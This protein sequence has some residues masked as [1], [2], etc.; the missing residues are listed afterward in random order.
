MS[1]HDIGGAIR[2]GNVTGTLRVLAQLGSLGIVYALVVRSYGSGVLGTWVLLQTLSTYGGL[3]HLGMGTLLSRRIAEK[4]EVRPSALCQVVGLGESLTLG[5]LFSLCLSVALLIVPWRLVGV[6]ASPILLLGLSAAASLRLFAGIYGG[7]L[8]GIHRNSSVNVSQMV[9]SIA[10]LLGYMLSPLSWT[11]LSRLAFGSLLSSTA[12]G[13]VILGSLHRRLPEALMVRPILNPTRLAELSRRAF[14]FLAVDG[15]LLGREPL[16]KLAAFASGG[17]LATASVEIASRVPSA[18]RQG[19]VFGFA[20]LLP[21][22]SSLAA[23]NRSSEIVDVGRRALRFVVLGAGLALFAYALLANELLRLWL[24]PSIPQDAVRLTRLFA[25]WWAV[26]AL[27]VPAWW[28]GM[29]VGHPG[30]NLK[31]AAYHTGSAAVIAVFAGVFK[32]SLL[33]IVLLWIGSGLVMQ[34]PLYSLT[35]RRTR[36]V[37]PMYLNDYSWGTAG[38]FVAGATCLVAG[39]WMYTRYGVAD[40]A[41]REL[42]VAC[43]VATAMIIAHASVRSGI[44]WLLARE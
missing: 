13:V 25:F 28:L 10:L 14:V 11:P 21:A 7:V 24:G 4:G 9:G 43:L 17:Q 2:R 15:A 32:P 41:S 1:S 36:L 30:D 26:T 42:A 44:K 38:L 20:S 18:V 3:T 5:T 19:F 27:N 23:Q 16:L 37:R 35:H 31:I 6:Q 39:R 8:I 12:E 29:G 34:M 22:F 40:H 33:I